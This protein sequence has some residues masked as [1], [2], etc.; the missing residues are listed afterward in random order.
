MTLSA[1]WVKLQASLLGLKSETNVQTD[2]ESLTRL[3][4]LS[5]C[6]G[7]IVKAEKTRPHKSL[8][9]HTSPPW[10]VRYGLHKVESI[11]C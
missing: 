11:F 9:S 5:R 3:D 8:I 2:E 7:R 4:K 6:A 1:N 10:T